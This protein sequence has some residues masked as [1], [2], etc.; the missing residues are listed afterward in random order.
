MVATANFK[1]GRET[2]DVD[3]TAVGTWRPF[4]DGELATV[5]DGTWSTGVIP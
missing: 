4:L 1:D 5:L 2:D 3:V